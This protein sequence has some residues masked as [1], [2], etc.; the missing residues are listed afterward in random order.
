MYVLTNY[1]K[2]CVNKCVYLKKKI[3]RNHKNYIIQLWKCIWS[4][5]IIYI[6]SYQMQL[7]KY[8]FENFLS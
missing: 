7:L 1:K 4:F 6:I 5:T 3:R 8:F 2:K